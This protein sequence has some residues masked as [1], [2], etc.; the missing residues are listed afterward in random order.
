[1]VKME[2]ISFFFAKGEFL[3]EKLLHGNSSENNSQA[4]RM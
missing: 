3:R 4:N 1:M 2:S